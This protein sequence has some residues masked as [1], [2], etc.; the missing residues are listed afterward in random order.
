MDAKTSAVA[1][2]TLAVVG[3]AVGYVIARRKAK[4]ES[5]ALKLNSRNNKDNPV[6]EY[7]QSHL[8]PLHPAQ[9]KLI[10]ITD[11]VPRRRMLSD[12]L[13]MQLI[14]NVLMSMGAKKT[15]DVGVYTGFSALTV[16]LAIPDDGKVV[17]CDIT[18]DYPKYGVP[19][20]KEA[21]VDHKID[22]RIAPAVESLQKML[23]GGE[24]G[25]Y[26]FMFIDADK[27]NYDNY[28]ELGL[29]LLRPGG[30]MALDNMLWGGQVMDQSVN[31]KD[32]IAL[33]AM[34]DK[35]AKD[36]RVNATHRVPHFGDMMSAKMKYTRRV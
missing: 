36:D 34:N 30:L 25:T 20:W 16:A 11:S 17:A 3:A 27:S 9:E 23:D 21:G 1:A 24:E 35:I 33:R 18:M 19:V 8:Q 28:Y 7:I 14:H 22:L 5:K 29:K 2:G 13:E 12:S 4:Y 26:D 15:I 6:A 31:D 32:T 10:K